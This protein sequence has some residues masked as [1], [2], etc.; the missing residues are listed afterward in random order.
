[1][2]NERLIE[3]LEQ[4]IRAETDCRDELLAKKAQGYVAVGGRESIDDLIAEAESRI[5][6]HLQMIKHL[7]GHKLA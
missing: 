2:A 3:L 6:G 4:M 7:T 5:K 1:M